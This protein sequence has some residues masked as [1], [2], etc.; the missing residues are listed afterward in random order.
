MMST[1]RYVSTLIFFV[2]L[3]VCCNFLFLQENHNVFLLSFVMAPGII[4]FIPL[5][6][7]RPKFLYRWVYVLFGVTVQIFLSKFDLM[8]GNLWVLLI[9]DIAISLLYYILLIHKRKS[10]FIITICVVSGSVFLFLFCQQVYIHTIFFASDICFNT[11]E[12]CGS[13]CYKDYN[14][15]SCKTGRFKSELFHGNSGSYYRYGTEGVNENVIFYDDAENAKYILRK[16]GIE[17][18]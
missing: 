16:K 2:F 15:V 12:Y 10:F 8:W 1:I 14:E 17:R 18:Q 3:S 6:L 13:S 11:E 5:L 9:G 4:P 7:P